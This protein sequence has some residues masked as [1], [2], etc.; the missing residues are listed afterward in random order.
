MRPVGGWLLSLWPEAGAP[1]PAWLEA[2]G[3]DSPVGR[4][5]VGTRLAR[6]GGAPL[7]PGLELT[8]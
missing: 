2:A 1:P 8:P 7:A 5:R 6:L 3:F 4:V